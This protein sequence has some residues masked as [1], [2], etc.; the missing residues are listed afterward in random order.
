MMKKFHLFNKLLVVSI[1]FGLKLEGSEVKNRH[2][3][4]LDT[5]YNRTYSENYNLKD[6]PSKAG[7]KS[8]LVN[9]RSNQWRCGEKCIHKR[10]YCIE[11]SQCHPNYPIPCGD[12]IRCYRQVLQYKS[13][14][15]SHGRLNYCYRIFF[16]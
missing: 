11:N 10:E 3:T 8:S 12:K 15:C 2:H 6:Q 13:S 7:K 4:V 9:C 1:L 16:H 14:F 5:Q